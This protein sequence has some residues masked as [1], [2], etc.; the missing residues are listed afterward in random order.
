[1]KR[2]SAVI[3]AGGAGRRFASA[4]PKQFLQ[5]DAEPVLDRAAEKFQDCPLVDDIIIVVP[6]AYVK[7]SSYLR[8]KFSKIRA[9][10]SG[11]EKRQDSVY[12]GLLKVPRG[13]GIALIH[14]GVRPAVTAGLITSVIRAAEKFGGAVPA[15]PLTDTIKKADNCGMIAGTCDRDSLFAAQTP[16]GFRFPEIKRAY[17]AAVKSM[18]AF[19]DCAAVYERQGFKVKIVQGE[20]TNIKIT[21][22][23]D[24]RPGGA[25]L[26]RVGTGYDIHR[27][28]EKRKLILG[29]VRI[30]FE[31]GLLGHSDADALTHAVCDSLLGAA[32]MRDIGFHFP[33]T[34]DRFKGVSSLKLLDKVVK[35]LADN[36]IS[37]ANVDTVIIMERPK[38]SGHIESIKRSLAGVL[39]LSENSIGVKAKTRE[40]MGEAGRGEAVEC[41]A[42]ALVIQN[43]AEGMTDKTQGRV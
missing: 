4:M 11:G 7:K 30:P 13:T 14:D 16:Q 1:M 25:G 19:T 24:L 10:V 34:D 42:T 9:I 41:Y 3:V 39:K 28:V 2:V 36:N 18:E 32:G 26:P 21:Y 27:L 15:L 12:R 37:I 23:E 35:M 43:S 33:D 8:K 5:L 29:G 22:R 6:A 40:G 20:K 17:A 38:L 31:K